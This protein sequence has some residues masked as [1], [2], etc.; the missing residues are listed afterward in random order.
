[1]AVTLFN[2]QNGLLH[3]GA[4]T[5]EPQLP[6]L[7][8]LGN[9]QDGQLQ[10]QASQSTTYTEIVFMYSLQEQGSPSNEILGHIY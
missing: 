1:M 10:K 5:K 6:V 8:R 4:G 7:P 9:K 3:D 2:A